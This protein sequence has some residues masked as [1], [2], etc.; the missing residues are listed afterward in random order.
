M[1]IKIWFKRA[2][3]LPGAPDDRLGSRLR[4]GADTRQGIFFKNSHYPIITGYLFSTAMLFWIYWFVS[5]THISH[6]SG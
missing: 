4:S 6:I 5:R 3:V 1:F 2:R